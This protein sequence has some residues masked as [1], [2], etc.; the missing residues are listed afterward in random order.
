M[1]SNE[2]KPED[3]ANTVGGTEQ[4]SVEIHCPNC[5][6]PISI[7]LYQIL[8]TKSICCPICGVLVDI[9]E[10]AGRKADDPWHF[11]QGENKTDG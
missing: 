11:I 2:L 5:R 3:L 4:S 8:I 9:P 7:T 10:T 6:K 1:T